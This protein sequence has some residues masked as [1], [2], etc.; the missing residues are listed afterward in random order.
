MKKALLIICSGIFLLSN[1]SNS[2]QD[3]YNKQI[4]DVSNQLEAQEKTI[5]ELNEQIVNM[6]EEISL[7]KKGILENNDTF[8]E[9]KKS[10]DTL[11]ISCLDLEY[12][13]EYLMTYNIL[14]ARGLN[15][16]EITI[17][18]NL[19][20][21]YS[22]MLKLTD[23]ELA[24]MFAPGSQLEG[25]GFDITMLSEDDKKKLESIG[26]SGYKAVILS[27]LGYS[28]DEMYH[29]TKEELDFI[30]PNTQ[31]IDK[32]LNKGLTKDEINQLLENGFTYKD[33]IK[34]MLNKKNSVP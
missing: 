29:I 32:L 15:H 4:I 24:K 27:N 14:I 30:F 7:V 17:L 18:G 8:N 20:M 23:E 16:N 10:I 34:D 9:N 31:L 12:N 13:V 5:N 33:I 26:V 22:E 6:V 19:G 28:E 1:C 3:R 2:S 21:D 25:Y 11:K